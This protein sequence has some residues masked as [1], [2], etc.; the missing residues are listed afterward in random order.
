MCMWVVMNRVHQSVSQAVSQSVC[1]L[2]QAEDGPRPEAAW[3]LVSG[4][5]GKQGQVRIILL[6]VRNCCSC[7]V[8]FLTFRST[9]RRLWRGRVERWSSTHLVIIRQQQ[10]QQRPKCCGCFNQAREVCTV[11][12]WKCLSVCL[13]RIELKLKRDGGIRSRRTEGKWIRSSAVSTRWGSFLIT[14]DI[15]I[16]IYNH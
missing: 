5:E 6:F 3:V 11:C 1:Q 12:R 16:Y 9:E 14:C 2:I 7:Q 8:I 15:H 10:Q 13:L 4:N